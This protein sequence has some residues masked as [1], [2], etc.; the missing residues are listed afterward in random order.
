MQYVLRSKP[1]RV[2]PYIFTELSWNIQYQRLWNIYSPNQI[3]LNFGR[4]IDFF[5]HRALL[6]AISI[7]IFLPTRIFFIFTFLLWWCENIWASKWKYTLQSYFRA[8]RWAFFIPLPFF[9]GISSLTWHGNF[10]G[11]FGCRFNASESLIMPDYGLEATKHQ[12][13]ILFHNNSSIP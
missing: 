8:L 12:T 1:I 3:F 13:K 11:A 5:F 10:P 2:L 4:K 6:R 7:S 9:S